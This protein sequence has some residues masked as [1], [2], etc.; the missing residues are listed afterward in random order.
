MKRIQWNEI[1]HGEMYYIIADETDTGFQFAER[2]IWEVR[3]YE[4]SPTEALIA[5]ATYLASAADNPN[6]HKQYQF[7]RQYNEES[8][9][10]VS[11][12]PFDKVEKMCIP[13]RDEPASCKHPW[14]SGSFY[15]FA[16]VLLVALGLIVEKTVHR[17]AILS[18]ILLFGPISICFIGAFQLKQ[19]GRLAEGRFLKL[20]L[21]SLKSLLL[22]RKK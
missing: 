17:I 14:G 10:R 18:V 4:L 12:M 16:L 11:E 15:L 21:E 5:K 22:F 3:W 20:V 9:I 2:S 6:L 19:D 8:V 7:H 13:D 1:R